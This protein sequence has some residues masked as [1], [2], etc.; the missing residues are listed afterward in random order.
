MIAD[1]FSLGMSAMKH[2][3]LRSWLT[4][5]GVFIGIAAIVSLISLGDGLE[6]AIGDIMGNM[7]KDTLFRLLFS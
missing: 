2:R 3:K 5:L 1:F 6:N 4:I 7:G